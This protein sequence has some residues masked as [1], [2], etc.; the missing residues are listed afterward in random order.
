MAGQRRVGGPSRLRFV[1]ALFQTDIGPVAVVRLLLR[2]GKE[3]LGS[4]G[5]LHLQPGIANLSI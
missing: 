3:H 1:I 2:L 5:I 4:F